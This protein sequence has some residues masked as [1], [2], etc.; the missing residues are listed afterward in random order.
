M[1]ATLP[2][3]LLL[4]AAL[5]PAR[6]ES[7]RALVSEGNQAYAAREYQD[8][9]NAYEEASKTRPDSPRIWF[10]KGDALYQQGQFRGA[11]D[12]YEQAALYSKDTGLAARGRFNQGNASFRDGIQQG[13]ANPSQAVAS[14]EKGVR[15]YQDALKLDPALDD[16]THNIEVARRAIQ[17]LREQMKNQPQQGD[18]DKDSEDKQ[19]DQDAA[20]NNQQRQKGEQDDSSE[21]QQEQQKEQNQ[22]QQSQA[23]AEQQKKKPQAT[24]AAQD[25]LNK[26]RD[27]K[28]RRQIHAVVGIRPV[29]KDW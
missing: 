9:L 4:L 1:T 3:S 21:Q 13:Q 8:A 12:A 15:L 24:E 14:L 10:N 29:D 19:S 16:A 20:A 27:N 28:R 18:Q 23:G 11:M 17:M 25:I 5:S 26:E 6:A 22:Q 2:C 7:A